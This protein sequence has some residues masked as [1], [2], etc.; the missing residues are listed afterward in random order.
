MN[1]RKS[2]ARILEHPILGK[3]TE[4]K[5]ILID[6][7]GRKIAAY[8]GEPIAAALTAAGIKVFRTTPKR[9]E[10]RGVFC[11]IGR[12]TD[13]I[14]TVND[15]PNIRTCVTPVQEGMKIRTQKGLGR[16]PKNT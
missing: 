2:S 10:P 13:C 12:C 7:D 15:Q 6:V 5:E 8:E 4:M 11:A 1:I 16:W 9:E 14:M 3:L